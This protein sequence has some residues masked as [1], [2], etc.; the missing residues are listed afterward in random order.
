MNDS[1][2]QRQLRGYLDR[3]GIG[4]RL[5]KMGINRGDKVRCGAREWAW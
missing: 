3:V 4:R 2:I 1:E 5:V